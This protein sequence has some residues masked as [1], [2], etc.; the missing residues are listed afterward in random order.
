MRTLILSLLL[1]W[2]GTGAAASAP[3][4]ITADY[5]NLVFFVPQSHAEK[6]REALIEVGAGKMG[7]YA[8]CS[9]S[10]QGVAR[11]RP[12]D[13]AQPAA[14]MLG[15]IEEMDEI[16]IE[17]VCARDLLSQAIAAV[18]QVHPYE[19]VGFHIYNVQELR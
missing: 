6:V 1:G 11:F 14:G 2:M 13:A 17:M 4:L 5:V 12:L 3:L 15:Q 19:K 18:K 7:N 10:M 9:F 16:R 8:S